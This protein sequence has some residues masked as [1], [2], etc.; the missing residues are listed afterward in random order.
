MNL[1]KSI[2]LVISL[3]AIAALVAC[4][5]S[6][7]NSNTNTPASVTPSTSSNNQSA[8]VNTAFTTPF[9]VT[10]TNGSGAGISGVSV[11]FTAPAVAAGV[12]T[13]TFGTSAAATDTETTN[14]SGVATTSQ[15]FTAGTVAGAYTVTATAGSVSGAFG[16]TNT[17]GTAA[18][19]SATGGATQSTV[20]GTAFGALSAT[21]VDAY[22]NGVSGATVTFTVQPVA[23]A[24]AS[25]A[26]T[27]TTDQETTGSNGVA[28]TSQT[29]TANSTTGSFTVSADFT[30][31][32]SGSPAIFNLTNSTSGLTAGNYVF[33]ST[34]SDANVAFYTIAGVITVANT[35]AITG[36][37]LDFSDTDPYTVYGEQIAGG[38]VSV[39]ADGNGVV[40]ID[41][42]STETYINGGS[43]ITFNFASVSASQALLSEQ[44]NWATGSGELD[45]QT[46]T[47][48]PCPSASSS[49]PCGYAF[50]V[51]GTDSSFGVAALG[52]V[53]AVDQAAGA[54][55]GTGSVFD[56]NDAGTT[57]SE[58]AVTS[59]SVSAPDSLGLGRISFT[60]NNS[61]FGSLI[62]DGYVI[63]ANHMRLVENVG[64]GFAGYMGGTAFAQTGTGTFSQSSVSGNTYVFGVNG[65][66]V[67]AAYQAAGALTFV[68]DGSVTGN[69]SYNDLN[70]L[71]SAQG[72]S[73]LT[74]ES[75][76]TPCS[77]GSST[78]ACYTVDS[79]GTGRVTLTNVTDGTV[80]YTLQFYL[81]GDNSG[82]AAVISMDSGVD[83]LNGRAFAQTSGLSTA[84]FSGS[85]SLGV[86]QIE[87]DADEQDGIGTVS[88]DGSSM[89][90]GFLDVNVDYLDPT[91]DESFAGTY[92]IGTSPNGVG[93]GTTTDPVTA[94]TDTFTYYVVSPNGT[95]TI[96]N[97]DFQETLGIFILQ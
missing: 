3:G 42:P 19:I 96:E 48:V 2:L 51:Y 11:T 80:N 25:F 59:G 71:I 7:N 35:G 8:V 79:S 89:L 44:D 81:T 97:D 84:S 37:E 24:G 86:T 56:L 26:T 52:G 14:S 83:V 61:L 73:T 4:S 54:F 27:G 41:L 87:T 46:S 17:S 68:S 45:L 39:S 1:R 63:D 9:S 53:I 43:P 70:S 23:G 77:G 78:T 88:A 75:T 38:T 92:A 28:T 36:G 76:S 5:S 91:P 60:L 15:T 21:V 40:T 32:T 49:T 72:G 74:A 66:D 55:D 67:D 12:A 33:S 62:L 50:S 94:A 30:G 6:N 58:N 47:S 16:L 29:L 34:G 95:V 57:Y 82:D 93:T 31:D 13:G 90:T 18:A 85:Y 22:G 69:V 65:A 20:V 10:V 64:D